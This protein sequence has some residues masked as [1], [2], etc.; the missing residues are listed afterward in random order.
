MI[1]QVK[2]Q[3][4][5]KINLDLRVLHR[6]LDGFHELRTVFQTISL[7]DTVTIRYEPARRTELEI[8][9]ELQIPDNLILRAARAVLNAMRTQARVH[10][11]LEKQIPMGGG[12]G[13]GSSNA[14]SVLL[15]LPVLAGK[16]LSA[17]QLL[18]IAESLGSDIPFFLVGG[19]AIGI[20]RGTELYSLPDVD[21]V[22]ILVIAPGV[23]VATGPAYQAL[24]RSLTFEESSSSIRTFQSFVR[25]LG[26]VCP[27]EAVDAF[28]AN[29]FESVVFSQ[30]P[31]IKKLAGRLW[32]S[33]ATAVRMTG[34]GSAIFGIFD[35]VAARD[36]A[37]AG[38]TR[39]RG[40][41][42]CRILPAE[43]LSRR[44]YERQWKNQLRGHVAKEF[45]A[46][47]KVT[48]PPRSRYAR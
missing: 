21:E 38:L 41:E 3:S 10:F 14:A 19:T 45:V 2:L 13:G 48:W 20:G 23:H 22:P 16:E 9:D 36:R 6:R 34:S 40:F 26:G 31:Q 42:G 46:G 8:D 25:A 17:E 12:L 27:A 43:L 4:F 33:G 47:D 39:E 35:S 5:A 15:A 37:R 24:S 29:D 7:A 28:G 32:K 11:H 44:S 1:R 30:Y 18:P